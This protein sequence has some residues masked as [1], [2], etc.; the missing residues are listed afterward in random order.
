MSPNAACS[1]RDGAGELG[2]AN[3]PPTPA[4]RSPAVGRIVC[5]S[6]CGGAGGPAE[7][8]PLSASTVKRPNVIV[9]TAGSGASRSCAA[10]VFV[11]RE[12][13]PVFYVIE[14]L[15]GR[16]RSALLVSSRAESGE[17]D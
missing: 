17:S 5:G 2:R 10:A 12:T 15:L 6:Q 1:L 3:E 7:R 9:F 4:S 16:S 13:N 14:L 11:S 8:P